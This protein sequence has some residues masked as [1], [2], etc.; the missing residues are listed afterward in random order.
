MSSSRPIYLFP[1]SALVIIAVGTEYFFRRRRYVYYVFDENLWGGV[2]N[3]LPMSWKKLPLRAFGG[4]V[5]R[6]RQRH[7]D[8]GILGRVGQRNRG[9]S[10][11]VSPRNTQC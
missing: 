4:T 6:T 1:K 11:T 3:T 5:Q 8:G 10:A 2:Q 7:G 9:E